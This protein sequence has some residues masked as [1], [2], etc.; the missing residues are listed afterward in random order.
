MYSFS[1]QNYNVIKINYELL[2]FISKM[3]KNR[4]CK[5]NKS[6]KNTTFVFYPYLSKLIFKYKTFIYL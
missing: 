1:T 3:G 4:R 5:L 6:N 2:E